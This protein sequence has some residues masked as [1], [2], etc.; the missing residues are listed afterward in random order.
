MVCMA[1][2]FVETL[3]QVIVNELLHREEPVCRDELVREVAASLGL[4]DRGQPV[5]SLADVEL[6]VDDLIR[7]GHVEQKFLKGVIAQ[8]VGQLFTLQLSILDRIALEGR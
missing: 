1:N 8:S 2:I 7:S 4:F 6:A 5:F 3:K